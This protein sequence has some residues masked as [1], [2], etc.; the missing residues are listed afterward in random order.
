MRTT[1]N[2]IGKA[3]LYNFLD[4]DHNFTKT[5]TA[6]KLAELAS[7]E[8]DLKIEAVNVTNMRKLMGLSA[9][10]GQAPVDDRISVLAREIISIRKALNDPLTDTF[11][12]EFAAYL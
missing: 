3:K 11:R 4:K 8:L 9:L 2:A 1:L 6:E 10:R 5:T 12:R 7:A